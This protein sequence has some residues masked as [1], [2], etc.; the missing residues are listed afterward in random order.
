FQIPD[1][2]HFARNVPNRNIL[3][4]YVKQQAGTGRDVRHRE[5][6]SLSTVLVE[7]AIFFYGLKGLHAPDLSIK[8]EER[9]HRTR[10]H[11]AGLHFYLTQIGQGNVIFRQT[12][13]RLK[14]MPDAS[15]PRPCRAHISGLFYFS[16]AF[17]K[18]IK[19][20]RRTRHIRPFL[21]ASKTC[22][23]TLPRPTYHRL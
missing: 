4:L 3:G 15:W 11:P 6:Q 23:L 20:H 10:I 16:E 14:R 13:Q 8:G 9:D 19:G 2:H 18:F 17:S 22:W 7:G 12:K 5:V 21:A 1:R